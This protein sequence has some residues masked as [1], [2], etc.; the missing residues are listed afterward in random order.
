[1]KHNL[2]EW[3]TE[4]MGGNQGLY[5]LRTNAEH[6]QRLDLIA[7]MVWKKVF[8]EYLPTFKKSWDSIMITMEPQIGEL[9][10]L[11]ML[12]NKA[13]KFYD[14]DW[15]CAIE[16]SV[17]EERIMWVAEEDINEEKVLEIYMTYINTLVESYKRL[18]IE[19][20]LPNIH[21]VAQDAIADAPFFETEL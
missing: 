8:L 12:Y 10:F 4:S 19:L 13:F 15:Y 1:M 6:E 2:P 20:N 7:D 5:I 16:S 11:P 17:L 9:A 14:P 18:K 3:I 21:L